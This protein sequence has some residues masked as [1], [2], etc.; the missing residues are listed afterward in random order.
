LGLVQTYRL[1]LAR[2]RLLLRA[3]RKG[4]ELAAVVD[5]TARISPGQV[6][7]FCTLRNECPRLAHFLRHYRALGVGHFLIV[8]N[9]SDD[10]SG[11][12]LADQPDVSLGAGRWH[13]LW[14]GPSLF[15]QSA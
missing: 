12:F 13:A 2:K 3:W 14:R 9:G 5:R 10:G 7:L 4:R 6:L 15:A 8:D 11:A 1:R